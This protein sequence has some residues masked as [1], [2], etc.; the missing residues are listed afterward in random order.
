MS[1]SIADG[2]RASRL[3]PGLFY[4]F[5]RL[6]AKLGVA[7]FRLE[8]PNDLR[9]ELPRSVPLP[10]D[11]DHLVGDLFAVGL[12]VGRELDPPKERHDVELVERSTDLLGVCALRILKGLLKHEAGGEAP[13]HVVRGHD[14]E[15]SRVRLGEAV[16]GDPVIRDAESLRAGLRVLHLRLPLRRTDDELRG[17]ADIGERRL[18]WRD[19]QRDESCGD[20]LF[21]ELLCERRP[22]REVTAADDRIGC[23]GDDLVDERVEVGRARVVTLANDD[24]WTL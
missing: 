12:G 23:R 24:L 21:V 15:L 6:L 13:S 3:M 10:L 1:P 17:V 14:V 7:G 19:E 2:M 11:V 4:S 9:A 18:G 16:D 20:L 5:V 22:I 8:R